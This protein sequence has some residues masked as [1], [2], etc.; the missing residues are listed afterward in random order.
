MTGRSLRPLLASDGL[1]VAPGAYD[2]LTARLIAAHGFPAVYMTGAGTSVAFGYPDYGLLTM[3]DMVANASRIAEAVDLP[4]IADAD[5]GYGNE[6]NVVRTV[7]AYARAGVAAIHLEDQTFPK[8][9]GHLAGKE[10]VDR[11]D[12]LRKLRAAAECR[13]DTE[14]LIIARTDARAVAG[15]D[16]AVER[17]NA[18]L[19]AG[20]DMVF[21]EAPETLEEVE[22][23]PR[24]V[25]GP[26]LF[27]AVAGGRSPSVSF[28]ELEAWG[29]RVVICPI[30][31]LGPVVAACE[32]ALRALARDGG[33]TGESPAGLFERVGAAD[34][35]T[36]RA[37][38]GTDDA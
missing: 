31:L 11:D 36:I 1:V 33:V 32:E 17:A 5:T 15:F 9:C 3:S 22:A 30:A 10:I 20:A 8:R 21:V 27:N 35:D 7:R 25:G 16:E 29:Y 24:L 4:V 18:A 12:W 13:P 14:L 26:C 2:A 23:V 37:R 28:A 6:L 34:W 19:D 38:Y